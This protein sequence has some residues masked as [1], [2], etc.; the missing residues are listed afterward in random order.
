M[1]SRKL[2]IITF[3]L[4]FTITPLLV[5]NQYFVKTPIKIN[6]AFISHYLAPD[7]IAFKSL[8]ERWNPS[9]QDMGF[10]V[11]VIAFDKE[12]ILPT[13]LSSKNSSIDI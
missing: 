8:I 7:A 1:R 4:L 9:F 11:N 3:I 12:S 13:I 10:Y 2:A 6:V 5:Y